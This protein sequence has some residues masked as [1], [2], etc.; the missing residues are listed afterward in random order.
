MEKG[1]GK[2]AP[3]QP[4][5][6]C[7]SFFEVHW[8]Y[9]MLLRCGMGGEMARYLMQ[10]TLA[11][12]T[13]QGAEQLAT[14]LHAAGCSGEVTTRRVMVN[15]VEG[16]LL[17]EFDAPNREALDGWLAA[18]KFH[19]DWVLRVEYETVEGKLAAV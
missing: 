16:K 10:S 12:L 1:K 7:F 6:Y 2:P 9:R 8:L 11:C 13:R 19:F 14:A 18:Q 3:A 17:G 4:L 15:M 5:F